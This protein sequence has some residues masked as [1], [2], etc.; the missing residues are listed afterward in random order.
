MYSIN[1]VAHI[2]LR[3]QFYHKL[4]PLE[5]QFTNLSPRKRID[6]REVLKNDDTCVRDGQVEIDAF[7]ILPN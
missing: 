1:P 5:A 2:V 6:L 4:L 7:M 3:M